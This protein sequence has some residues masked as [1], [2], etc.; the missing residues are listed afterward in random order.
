MEKIINEVNMCYFTGLV[1]EKPQREVRFALDTP[2][3][4][5]ATVDLYVKNDIIK[6][7]FIGEFVEY[8][9][10]LVDNIYINVKAKYNSKE[11]CFYVKFFKPLKY[12]TFYNSNPIQP[13]VIRC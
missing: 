1:K 12:Q 8:A 2:S 5:C 9:L 6:L 13:K 4:D 3:E 11:N 10:K 7:K